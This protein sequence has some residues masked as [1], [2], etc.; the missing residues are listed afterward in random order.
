M[1]DRAQPFHRPDADTGSESSAP[2]DRIFLRDHVAEIEI[3]A[4]PEEQGVTQRLRFSIVLEVAR[5]TAHMDDRVGRVINYDSI[6]EAIEALASGPRITLLE[7]FAERLAQ[8][9]L[10]D[11]RARR[12]HICVEKLDRLPKGAVLGCEI[13]RVRSPEANERIWALAAEIEPD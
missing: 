2:A 13:T 12:V 7:T 6:L 4:Y 5:N 8:L 1:I 3:G 10:E 11:P 9:L